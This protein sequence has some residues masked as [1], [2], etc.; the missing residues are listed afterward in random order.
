MLELVTR[1]EVEFAC[2]RSPSAPSRKRRGSPVGMTAN[3]NG[4]VAETA[5]PEG[6]EED[7][8]QDEGGA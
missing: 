5:V 6:Q 8:N 3:L 2:C 7:A 1:M 4:E